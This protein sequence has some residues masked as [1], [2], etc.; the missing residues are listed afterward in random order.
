[1]FT[2]KCSGGVTIGLNVADISR[3]VLDKLTLLQLLKQLPAFSGNRR[4]I[5]AFTKARYFSLPASVHSS[6]HTP[7]RFILKSEKY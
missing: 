6:L 1:M 4:F 3:V 7:N 5:T 2:H